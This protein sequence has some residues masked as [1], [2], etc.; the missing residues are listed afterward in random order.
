MQEFQKSVECQVEKDLHILHNRY[1]NMPY[2]RES[3]DRLDADCNKIIVRYRDKDKFRF[4]RGM[5]QLVKSNIIAHMEYNSRFDT[6]KD[7]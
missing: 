4:C 7:L 6:D 3:L 2:T 1:W 5:V